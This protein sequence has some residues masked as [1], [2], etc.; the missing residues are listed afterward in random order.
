MVHGHAVSTAVAVLIAERGCTADR[1]LAVLIAAAART[2]ST[3]PAQARLVVDR[4]RHLHPVPADVTPPRSVG[5]SGPPGGE[6]S[7]GR[8]PT[9]ADEAPP[10]C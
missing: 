1:A 7:G 4:T 3:V 9:P 5:G 10:A 2:G 6:P 8:R